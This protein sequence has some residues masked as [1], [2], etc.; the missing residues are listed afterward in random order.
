M[1]I[2]DPQFIVGWIVGTNG[3]MQLGGADSD[4]EALKAAYDLLKTVLDA[5]EDPDRR[6]DGRTR[7]GR[8]VRD[9]SSIIREY[10]LRGASG[11]AAVAANFDAMKQA[12]NRFSSL[13]R[14]GRRGRGKGRGDADGRRS[15]ASRAARIYRVV[16]HFPGIPG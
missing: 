16:R 12:S 9:P 6:R 8:R 4:E 10:S 5:I 1:S 15:G 2:L 13:G 11:R 14:D 7:Q 3:L